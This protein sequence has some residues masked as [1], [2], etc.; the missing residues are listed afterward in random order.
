MPCR[1]WPFLESLNNR[2]EQ[3]HRNTNPS[4]DRKMSFRLFEVKATR[5]PS[6]KKA[7][8]DQANHLQLEKKVK[9]SPVQIVF[10]HFQFSRPRLVDQL[11]ELGLM[12]Q[13]V[14]GR[15]VAICAKLAIHLEA[16]VGDVFFLALLLEVAGR[17]HPTGGSFLRWSVREFPPPLREFGDGQDAPLPR[18]RRRMIQSQLLA[19]LVPMG[20][21]LGGERVVHHV[22]AGRVCTKFAYLAQDARTVRKGRFQRVSA[23]SPDDVKDEGP[24]RVIVCVPVTPHVVTGHTQERFHGCACL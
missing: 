23:M 13:H 12:M 4:S 10:N 11:S 6:Q 9:P 19:Y 24:C 2:I 20:A 8:A 7:V 1:F 21:L 18:A 16:S 14:L 15:V 22:D 17:A 3:A 5:R